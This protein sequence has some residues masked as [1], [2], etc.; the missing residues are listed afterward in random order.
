LGSHFGV[1]GGPREG[2]RSSI[3][4]LLL[5]VLCVSLSSAVTTG[6]RAFARSASP[7]RSVAPKHLPAFAWSRENKPLRIPLVVNVFLAGLDYHASENVY[8]A[9]HE[10]DLESFLMEAFPSHQPSCIET[11]EKLHVA[12]DLWYHVAHVDSAMVSDLE[13]AVRG[14]LEQAKVP[15]GE[16]RNAEDIVMYDVEVKGKVLE[17]LSKIY[18][19]YSPTSAKRYRFDSSGEVGKMDE[20]AWFKRG[21]GRSGGAGPGGDDVPVVQTYSLLIANLKKRHM[22]PGIFGN[23][24]PETVADR[25]QYR[26][27][28]NGT[29]RSD[30]FLANGRFAFVDLS[31]GPSEYGPVGGEAAMVTARTL[32]RTNSV[33]QWATGVRSSTP[34]QS[35]LVNLVRSAVRHLFAPDI[36]FDQLDSSDE[37]LVAIIVLRDHRIFDPLAPGHTF[38]IDV[39]KIEEQVKRLALPDQQIQVV[40][41]VHNLQE[42]ERIAIAVERSVRSSTVHESRG[43]RYQ[44]VQRQ[45]YDGAA[46]FNELGQTGD[47]LAS[48]LLDASDTVHAKFFGEGKGGD[49]RRGGG[50]KDGKKTRVVPVYV[51]SMMNPTS[52]LMFEGGNMYAVSE[53]AVAALQHGD[54]VL[55]QY[56]SAGHQMQVSPTDPTAAIIGGLAS[57]VA[58]ITPPSQ[59]YDH[60]GASGADVLWSH[61]WTP[62]GPLGGGKTLSQVTVDHAVRNAVLSRLDVGLD[63]GSKVLGLMDDFAAKY[64]FD[65][66]GQ[67]LETGKPRRYLLDR[68]YR[69]VMPILCSIVV[70]CFLV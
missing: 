65:D 4:L 63:R 38:S 69:C 40:S 33:K 10:G 11:K 41:G 42:H 13:Q 43:G 61:G 52:P 29:T 66:L 26:Y 46:L 60:T 37:I 57:A 3:L 15:E 9:V 32:P 48:G 58:G 7:F 51:L 8:T 64:L 34:F 25:F 6:K 23:M 28:F 36:L 47:Y 49:S 55:L 59:R 14:N 62:F 24:E 35:R 54:S 1:M 2:Q 53:Q 22:V 18:D 68:F 30:A 70:D 16:T 56:A 19:V 17:E 27:A 21:G 45:Y 44:T 12:Y 31:S 5:F 50:G 67:A 39:S 20:G